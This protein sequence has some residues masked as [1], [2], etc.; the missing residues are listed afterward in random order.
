MVRPE[1]RS[2][3][4]DYGFDLATFLRPGGS[5]QAFGFCFFPWSVF[6][7]YALESAFIFANI[8]LYILLIFLLMALVV[9]PVALRHFA[10]LNSFM[11]RSTCPCSWLRKARI[12]LAHSA[13]SLAGALAKFFQ[14]GSWTVTVNVHGMGS[15]TPAPRLPVGV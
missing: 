9:R 3:P 1:R 4:R 11:A 6:L 8:A 14:R 5:S 15:T 13:L 12:Y 7:S 10:F 2:F